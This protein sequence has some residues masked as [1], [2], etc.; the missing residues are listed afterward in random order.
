VLT[1]GF[2]TT[3]IP[4]G[5]VAP[6]SEDSDLVTK[7]F[8]SGPSLHRLLDNAP[9]IVL[10]QFCRIID[11]GVIAVAINDIHQSPD[12]LPSDVDIRELLLDRIGK[13]D[14]EVAAKIDNHAQRIVTLGEGRGGEALSRVIEPR[15]ET[16]TRAEYDAQQDALGRSV[17]AYLHAR[18]HFDDAE[19][20]FYANHYRNYG[21][22]YEAFELASDATADFIWNA[23]LQAAL[24]A[25][26]VEELELK[27]RC[28]GRNNPVIKY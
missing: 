12:E 4:I 25:R 17:W 24:E 23:E 15:L 11:K 9:V 10:L 6:Y 2:A 28:S 8:K 19:S 26:V 3:I 21:K 1:R 20:L 7:I 22:M 5:D 16:N 27:G 18:R 14:Q 13:L